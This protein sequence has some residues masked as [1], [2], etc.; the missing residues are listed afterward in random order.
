MRRAAALAVLVLLSACAAKPAPMP[1]TVT[2]PKFPDYIQPIPPPDLGTPA[3]VERHHV[4]W[5]WLQAG[6]LRAAERNFNSALKQSPTFYPAEVGLGYVALANKKLKDALLHFD[7]AVVANPRYAPALAARAEVLLATGETDEAEQSI[8]AALK[9]SPNLGSLRSRLEV[10]RFR[11]RQADISRARKL[12]ESGN[13]D[14]AR[15]AYLIALEASPDS[16]FLLRELAEVERRAGNAE[17]A[18]GYARRATEMEPDEP[19]GHVILG[20]LYESQGDLAKAADAYSAAVTLLPDE[21]LGEKIERLRA[22]AAFEAMPEEYRAIESAETVSRAQLAALLAVRLEPLLTRSRR[23]NAV[24]ITDTRNNW[25]SNHILSVA[26]AGVMEVYSNHTFQPDAIVR[27]G[28]LA[29]AVSRV[30]DLVAANHPQLAA[31]WRRD[32]RK[33]PDVSPR[34]FSYPAVAL[35]VEAGVMAPLDD[36]SFQPTRPITGIEAIAAVEKLQELG[37]RPV[38]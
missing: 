37:G 6:D 19:R 8:E 27:R 2:A 33:F 29:L 10:L 35:A 4:G 15:G 13:L 14:E 5:Q 31:E 22:R 7:R 24:V 9:E 1:P 3:A 30:L 25:A 16:P 11:A 12:A 34:H 23:V 32:R 36:G 20:E 17:T 28:D 38:R 18:L 21:A 26:R